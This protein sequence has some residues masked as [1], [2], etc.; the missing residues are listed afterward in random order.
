MNGRPFL[1]QEDFDELV[2]Q[3]TSSEDDDSKS[4]ESLMLLGIMLDLKQHIDK[5]MVGMRDQSRR[6]FE[7][8]R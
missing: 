2:V 1:D 4:N 6:D 8:R 3:T 7:K 5:T